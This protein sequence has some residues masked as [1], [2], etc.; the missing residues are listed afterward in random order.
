MYVYMISI[1]IANSNNGYHSE[2]SLCGS[3]QLQG[4]GHPSTQ[5]VN[6]VTTMRLENF[7]E[8]RDNCCMIIRVAYNFAMYLGAKAHVHVQVG[9]RL[10]GHGNDCRLAREERRLISDITHSIPKIRI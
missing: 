2:R 3:L 8:R 7:E 1:T 5:K 9:D 6:F 10:F 4:L